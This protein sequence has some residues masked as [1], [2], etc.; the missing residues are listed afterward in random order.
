MFQNSPLSYSYYDLLLPILDS[1]ELITFNDMYHHKPKQIVHPLF[2]HYNAFNGIMIGR[3]KIVRLFPSKLVQINKTDQYINSSKKQFSSDN[4]YI[5]LQIWKTRCNNPRLDLVV[6]NETK[7]S[8]EIIKDCKL[9]LKLYNCDLN[10]TFNFD[11]VIMPYEFFINLYC[12]YRF[13]II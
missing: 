10:C 6:F 4:S 11:S 8:I 3:G 7:K 13:Y 2:Y 12:F 1:T 5:G 9:F